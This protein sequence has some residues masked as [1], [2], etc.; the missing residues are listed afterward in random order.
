[1]NVYFGHSAINEFFFF[2][3]KEGLEMELK[4]KYF[5]LV[6]FK[7]NENICLFQ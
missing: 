5:L 3:F 2:F 1:M 7:K 4:Q 6:Y